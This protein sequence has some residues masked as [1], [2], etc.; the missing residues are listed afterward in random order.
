[1]S[2]IDLSSF[3][4]KT[5]GPREKEALLAELEMLAATREIALRRQAELE[6]TNEAYS[7]A[8]SVVVD[9]MG[10]DDGQ[11][12]KFIAVDAAAFAESIE[13]VAAFSLDPVGNTLHLVNSYAHAGSWK[14]T[15]REPTDEERGMFRWYDEL[16]EKMSQPGFQVGIVGTPKGLRIAEWTP[17]G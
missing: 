15:K 6:A 12:K 2:A 13:R 7:R 14:V 9:L 3:K 8:L 16:P 17:G 4:D 5:I 10:E 11:G 1:M